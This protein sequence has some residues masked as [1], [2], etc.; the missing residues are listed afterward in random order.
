[1]R[2]RS[3]ASRSSS[4]C[5]NTSLTVPC[6]ATLPSLITTALWAYSAT[7]HMVWVTAMIVEPASFRPL[8]QVHHAALFGVIQARGRLVQDQDLRT[9]GEYARHRDPL[10]LALG[11]SERVFVS[12]SPPGSPR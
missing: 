8:D 12:P 7:T 2:G 6:R 10:A 11:E 4:S 1:M 3:E 9:H 5:A